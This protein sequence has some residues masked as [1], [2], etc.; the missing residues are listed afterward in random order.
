LIADDGSYPE[1]V[2]AVQ[3]LMSGLGLAL[4]HIWQEDKGWRKN[5]ILNK[6]VVA[7]HSDYLVLIDGDWVLHPHFVR[8]HFCGGKLGPQL[9]AGGSTSPSPCPI[10]SPQSES[11]AAIYP[12]ESFGRVP[13]DY[14]FG[15]TRRLHQGIYIPWP[16]LFNFLNRKQKGVLGSNFSLHKSDIEQVNGFDERFSEPGVGE[17]TDIEMRL[18]RSGV[19]VKSTRN[20]AI[21][22]LYHD[23]LP[24]T[25]TDSPTWRKTT[26]TG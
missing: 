19:D 2:N 23:K 18:R 7:S 5:E 6:C 21:Q 11:G 3:D 24:R 10:Y 26:A 9:P 15:G 12:G 20:R 22:F 8:E 17:D 1:S 25:P 14:L 4:R 13:W 16:P